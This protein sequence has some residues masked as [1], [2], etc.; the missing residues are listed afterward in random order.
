MRGIHPWRQAAGA[1]AAAGLETWLGLALLAGAPAAARPRLACAAPTLEFGVLDNTNEVRHTF[2]LANPGDARLEIL[3][4]H[5]G[6]GCVLARI[7]DLGI[8]PGGE[9]GL[10]VRLILKG[11]SGRQDHAVWIESNDP[12]TPRLALRLTGEA[13]ADVV[14]TPPQLYWGNVRPEST[15]AQSVEIAFPPSAPARIARAA[16]GVPWLTVSVETNAPGRRYRLWVRPAPPLPFGRFDR[17]LTVEADP[18]RRRPVTI[19][20]QGRVVGALYAVPEELWFS[21]E[22]ADAPAQRL[23]VVQSS[24]RQPFAILG[25]AAPATNIQV[26]ARPT[27]TQGYR[28]ELRGILPTPALDG[29]CLVITTDCAETPEVRIP[30][31]I[32]APPAP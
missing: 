7:D 27:R 13:V 12:D 4:V 29:R 24:R 2:R 17:P 6:C 16:C 32:G 5:T 1:A 15:E 26:S 3:R 19:P 14:L 28:L 11:R 30:F 8:P 23:L 10:E 9:L 22:S 31:R 25:I 20:M 21:P 18:P